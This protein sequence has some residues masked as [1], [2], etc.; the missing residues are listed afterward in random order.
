MI[1]KLKSLFAFT[2]ILIL[3]QACD[4]DSEKNVDKTLVEATSFLSRSASE[5]K[6][7]I[8]A[9]GLDVP[10][11][12]IQYDVE[13]F[14]VTY[15]T[16]YKGAEITASGLVI[17]PQTD[18]DVS[19]LSFQH[20]TIAAHSQAPT[21]L[22]IN[23]SE[24]IYYTALS[25]IG[26]IAVIPDFIGFGESSVIPHPYYVE[27]YTA[28][29]VIDLLQAA[30]EL[31]AKR[32]ISFDGELFLAGYSQGGYATM[33]AH[34]FIEERGFP[35]FRLVASFPAA[36]GYDIKGVQEYFFDQDEYD[37][38][39]YLAYVARSYQTAYNWTQPL[40]QF[41]QEPYASRIPDLFNGSKSGSEINAQLTTTVANLIT[42]DILAEI[43]TDPQYAYIV[44][45]FTENSLTDWVP[46]LPMYLYHGDADTT[47]PYENSVSV[48]ND[49][50]S[51]GA[52]AVHFTRLP[53]ADHGSGVQPYIEDFIAIMLS[54]NE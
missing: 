49:F 50:V 26:M 18:D 48:Y 41:F 42:A 23:S 20:G 43:D 13:I 14:H 34:K 8:G 35:G 5:M 44:D 24:L 7:F 47:V 12:E 51:A 3:I 21:A 45:A 38:P 27:E 22:P 46:E 28:N 6:T 15:R 25:T 32:D 31:A 16:H 52:G 39:Y 11:D 10:L 1:S 9:S 53:G 40:S 2:A 36:G 29:A 30:K 4:S 33:A 54:L 17:L 37:Q 19:M